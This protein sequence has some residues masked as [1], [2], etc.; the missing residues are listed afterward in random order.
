M[1]PEELD[2]KFDDGE[3]VLQYFDPSS[4]KRPGLEIQQLDVDF[5]RWMIEAL[6]REA[7]RL[8]IDR[9]AVIKVWIA[10]RL[11]KISVSG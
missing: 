4:L 1:N 2:Q 9:K 6:D 8:G 5:P 3:D 11:D 10:E 7:R